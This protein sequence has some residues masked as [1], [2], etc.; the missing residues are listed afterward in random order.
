[1]SNSSA[2]LSIY[3]VPVSWDWIH[4]LKLILA[5]IGIIGNSFVIHIFE[6]IKAERYNATNTFIAAL[7]VAD[8]ITSI[9]HIPYPKLSRIHGNASGRFYCKVVDSSN[10]MWVSI[11]ASVFT[12]TTLSIERYL[13]VAYPLKYKDYFTK[14]R[15]ITII[16]F[17]WLASFGLNALLSYYITFVE[18]GM[19]VFSFPSHGYRIFIGI[20]AFLI[21][22]FVPVM[23]MISLNI[24]T[25]LILKRQVKLTT[26][27][28][29]NNAK[30][31]THRAHQE[32]VQILLVVVITFIIC[33][34]PDQFCFFAFNVGLLPHDYL[35]S[36]LHTAFGLMAFSNSCA[37]P[38][39]YAFKNKNFRR[40]LANHKV[41]PALVQQ[42]EMSP[43]SLKPRDGTL[44][45]DVRDTEK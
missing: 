35:F 40:A 19:C 32:I 36:P 5:I 15:T 9:C 10:I 37:N 11:V 8:L 45:N 44:S 28:S 33:W 38:F 39:I 24:A 2:S 1:M 30:N 43:G 16:C 26:C 3:L 41:S 31:L 13:A 6:R 12:L 4:V 23:L 22:Y 42:H 29:K 17:L 27:G 21:K 25:M 20:A 18:D 7:A 34:S 14:K